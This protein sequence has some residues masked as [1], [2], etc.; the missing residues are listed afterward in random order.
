MRFLTHG[1]VSPEI[2]ISTQRHSKERTPR[3]PTCVVEGCDAQHYARGYC[4]KHYGRVMAHGDPNT[5]LIAERGSGHIDE[6]GYRR[7]YMN[8]SRKMR[9]EHRIV[10]ESSLGRP[11]YPHET[12]HHVNGDRLDNRVENLELWSSRQPKGQR[13]MDKV[14]WALEILALYPEVAR[15]QE[16]Q[17]GQAEAG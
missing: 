5:V 7:V 12:V 3:D 13:V 14:R 8:G 15:E 10:M 11:L 9:P 17:E 6:N 2:P 4:L 1:H 16:A